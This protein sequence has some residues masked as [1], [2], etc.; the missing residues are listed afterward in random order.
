M[1]ERIKEFYKGLQVAKYASFW[2]LILYLVIII[3]LVEKRSLSS[4]I[5]SISLN[6]WE[7]I[8][9]YL[10]TIFSWPVIILTISLVFLFRFTESIKIFLE[11]IKSFKAGPVEVSQHQRGSTPQDIEKEVVENLQTK[12]VTFTDT[13]LKNIEQHIGSLSN[14]VQTVTQESQNKDEIIKYLAERSELFEFAYLNY[15][16]VFNTKQALR[17]FNNIQLK[18]STK[19]NFMLSCPLQIQAPNV[20]AEKEAI[21]NTLFVNGLIQQEQGGLL[22]KISEKG[23]RYLRSIGF[24]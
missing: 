9:S 3:F 13:E 2:W 11:N 6:G 14:Q 17:W 22:Y 19:E 15:F 4:F 24:N 20:V 7:T 5:L 1:K 21:F 23:V 10:Q 8:R 12:G 16:L 18:T